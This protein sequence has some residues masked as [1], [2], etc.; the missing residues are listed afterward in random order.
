M[1]LQPNY[2][3]CGQSME[4]PYLEAGFSFYDLAAPGT[5]PFPPNYYIGFLSQRWV[6]E[7]L[8]VPLNYTQSNNAVNEAFS[9]VGD[10]VRGG[11]LQ[12]LGYILDSGI[13]VALVYG[14]RDF[15]CN[16]IGGENVSLNVP[17]SS[18]SKFQQAGYT[19]IKVNSSY[20]GGQVRQYGNLSFSRVYQSGHE[21]P[22]YQ[23]QTAYEIFRRAMGGLDIATGGTT[24]TNDYATKGTAD[25][26]SIKMKAPAPPPSECYVLAPSTCD[27]D[28]YNSVLNG[29]AKVTDWIVNYN[30]SKSS[31]N[32]PSSSSGPKKNAASETRL[33]A[34]WMLGLTFL[35]FAV[36]G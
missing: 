17:W 27:E 26:W 2:A 32:N 24:V 14:D 29:T 23:P 1:Y 21:V 33:V 30:P 16:W 6:Q 12:D 13:K 3:Y 19:D 35:T 25:T 36:L 15:A 9:N 4:E 34:W 7:A 31:G 8:G 20:V 18:Q 10:I 28:T 5:T 22:A 11:L